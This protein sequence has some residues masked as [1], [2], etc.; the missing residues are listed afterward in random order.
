MSLVPHFWSTLNRSLDWCWHVCDVSGLLR[1]V[2]G[3]CTLLTLW[4]AVQC[5][6]AS[7]LLSEG[8][9]QSGLSPRCVS[10]LLPLFVDG[11]MWV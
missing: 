4:R 3:R 9:L 7:D 8:R 2:V 10:R 1:T 5:G 6:D 11:V